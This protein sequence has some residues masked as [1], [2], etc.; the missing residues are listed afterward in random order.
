MRRKR[1][2]AV[3]PAKVR[4]D[5]E[6]VGADGAGRT[7]N[8]DAFRQD[9]QYSVKTEDEAIEAAF[10]ILLVIEAFACKLS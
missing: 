9:G 4:D 6:G 5:F 1:N 7:E 8:G 3:F 10:R 2:R